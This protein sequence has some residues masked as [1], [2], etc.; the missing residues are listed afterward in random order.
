MK[1][2]SLGTFD[3]DVE[4]LENGNYNVR[5]G[6]AGNYGSYYENV[7]PHRIGDLLAE[8]IKCI[9]EG[10]STAG[11]EETADAVKNVYYTFGSAKQ[12]PYHHGEYVLVRALSFDDAHKT[13]RAS[14]PDR[15][16]NTLNCADYYSEEEFRSIPEFA[17]HKCA[18]TLISPKASVILDSME[19]LA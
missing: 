19:V 18:L 14:F 6:H 13:F 12:F 11:F 2:I 1:K 8:D 5:V 4:L 15:V 3:V 7:T 9:A 17:N 10:T 16:P